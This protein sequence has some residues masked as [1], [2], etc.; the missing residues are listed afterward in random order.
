MNSSL[1]AFFNLDGALT[2]FMAN[3]CQN[4]AVLPFDETWQKSTSND[5]HLFREVTITLDDKPAWYAKTIIS[6]LT[7]KT[8]ENYFNDLKKRPLGNYIFSSKKVKRVGLTYHL[9]SPDTKLYQ[10]LIHHYHLTNDD[11]LW[12]RQSTF[13]FNGEILK[14]EEVFFPIIMEYL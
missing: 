1:Q 13:L 4:I 14:I 6:Q 8:N 11:N 7:Y 9:L 5:N 2:A 3:R 10:Q 12:L